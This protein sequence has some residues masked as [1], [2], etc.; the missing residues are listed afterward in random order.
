MAEIGYGAGAGD[1][2]SIESAKIIE[3][4]MVWGSCWVLSTSDDDW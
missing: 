3:L 1:E 4:E 2:D